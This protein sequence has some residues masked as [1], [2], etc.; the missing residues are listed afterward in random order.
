[1]SVNSTMI[2]DILDLRGVITPLN[3]LKCKSRLESM[4]EGDF[5]KVMLT[6]IDVVQD[7]TTIVQR[8]CDEIV[9]KKEEPD[10]IYLKIKKG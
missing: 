3:L 2:E 8:S 5:L 4:K 10:C 9:Y 1:M 6:D 7:L